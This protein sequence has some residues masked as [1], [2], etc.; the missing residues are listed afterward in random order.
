MKSSHFFLSYFLQVA[1]APDPINSILPPAFAEMRL[2]TV[3]PLSDFLAGPLSA[4]LERVLL[5]TPGTNPTSK[6]SEPLHV[7]MTHVCSH[8]L[9]HATVVANIII[10]FSVRVYA[11]VCN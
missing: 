2:G 1:T 8:V 3:M 7:W 5:K 9:I 4:T 11:C 10:I 6:L